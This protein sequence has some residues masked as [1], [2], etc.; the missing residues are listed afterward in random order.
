[1]DR[2]TAP[3]YLWL[4]CLLYVC[5]ILNHTYSDAIK[6][7]PM[8]CLT[9]STVD[10]SPLLHFQFQ[11]RVYYKLDDSD[12]PSDSCKGVAWFVGISETVGHAMTYK[13]LTLDT[14]K[15]IH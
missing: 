11:E 4:C 12:F 1:M 3:A 14:K 10:I 8:Q 7:V 13:L 9:G 5:F 2:T 15:I 6:G